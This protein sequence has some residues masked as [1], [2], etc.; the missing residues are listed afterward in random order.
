V[1]IY[2]LDATNFPAKRGAEIAPP[3][4]AVVVDALSLDAPH[5]HGLVERVAG[6]FTLS[7][8]QDRRRVVEHQVVRDAFPDGRE[9]AP[10]VVRETRRAD[11]LVVDLSRASS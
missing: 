4:H 1:L 8:P 9:D 6:A 7:E 2:A 10:E 5:D 3:P 11:V